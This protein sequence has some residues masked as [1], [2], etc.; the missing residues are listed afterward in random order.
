[1]TTRLCRECQREVIWA[2]TVPAGKAMPL[3]PERRRP[4]DPDANVAVY[5]D[6]LGV[7]RARV[8]SADA[9]PEPYEWLAMP[10]FATCPK[11]LTHRDARAG[12]L[13]DEGVIPFPTATQRKA[14]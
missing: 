12:R 10:H 2:R 6:H 11:R 14:R 3:D 1:M 4:D 8:L 7:L 5:R 13:R 9:R